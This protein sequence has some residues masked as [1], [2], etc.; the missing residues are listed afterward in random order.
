MPN[1]ENFLMENVF[2]LKLDGN[3]RKEPIHFYKR[4]EKN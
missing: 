3:F 2:S 4:F 1:D